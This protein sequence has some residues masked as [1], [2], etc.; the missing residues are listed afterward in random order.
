VTLGERSVT[1]RRAL[2]AAICVTVFS[3]VCPAVASAQVWMGS[4]A[5]H[6]GSVE[7]S[8]GALWS[9]GYDVDSRNA[10]E[11]RNTGTGTG[12]FVLFATTSRILTATGGVARLGVY[13]SHSIGVEAGVQ[14]LRPTLETRVTGD[15]E[16]S[17]DSVASEPITR[18]VV[19]GSLVLHLNKLSFA[20]GKAVPFLSGGGGYI[21]EVHDLNELIETGREYHGGGGLKVWFGQGTHRFG[22]RAD[23]GASSRKGGF[24]FGTARRTVRTAAASVMYLF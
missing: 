16:Q 9:R 23:I 17:T 6:A 4:T 5:P 8:G 11:T 21:R 13:L 3:A 2:R 1:I 15:A 20:G 10:E 19:D 24:D 22:I 14:Y 18:Y 7:V 12:P